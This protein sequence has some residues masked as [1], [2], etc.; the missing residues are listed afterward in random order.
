MRDDR[1]NY[2]RDIADLI[3]SQN[4][5]TL[6]PIIHE[7]CDYVESCDDVLSLRVGVDCVEGASCPRLKKGLSARY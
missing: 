5:E 3:A 2:R 7:P 1:G 6:C 4:E